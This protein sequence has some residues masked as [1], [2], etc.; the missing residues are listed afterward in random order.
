VPHEEYRRMDVAAWAGDTK[1]Y[2]LDANNVLSP[3]QRSALRKN[4]CCI[5]SIGMGS[6]QWLNT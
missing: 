6:S 1:P 5:E 2:V 4:G 3:E